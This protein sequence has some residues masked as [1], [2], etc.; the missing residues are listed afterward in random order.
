MSHP[1]LC[2]QCKHF[3]RHEMETNVVRQSDGQNE[4]AV[5][6]SCKWLGLPLPTI[7]RENAMCCIG[8]VTAKDEGNVEQGGER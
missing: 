7:S 5:W 4:R 1:E 3:D 6:Y 8:F 2:Y